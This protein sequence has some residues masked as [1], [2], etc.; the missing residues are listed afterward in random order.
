MKRLQQQRRYMSI[1]WVH[2]MCPNT[3]F[4]TMFDLALYLKSF[5]FCFSGFSVLWCKIAVSIPTSY[6]NTHAPSV[7]MI[8]RISQIILLDV[9]HVTTVWERC[10]LNITRLTRH[11]TAF[12][13][14]EQHDELNMWKRSQTELHQPKHGLNQ[15]DQGYRTWRL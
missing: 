12:R 4:H 7:C 11:M 6:R 8:S 10:H 5:G 3:T 1:L 2:F 15:H 14:T 9:S 13:G